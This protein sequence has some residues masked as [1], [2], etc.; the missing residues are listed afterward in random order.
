MISVIIVEDQEDTRFLLQTMLMN[1]SS[2][3]CIGTAVNGTESLSLIPSLQ[4]DVVLMDIG[5]PDISGVECVRRLK[6]SCPKVEFIMCTIMDTAESVFESI[7]AGASSYVLKN[8][9]AAEIITTIQEV[10]AG[11]SPMDGDI[12]RKMISVLQHK[13]QRSD[14]GITPKEHEV[15]ES[16]SKGFTYQEISDKL[17]ISVKTLKGHIYR[18]YQKLQVNNR[19][20]AINKYLGNHRQS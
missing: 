10:H 15:L 20:E 4:P 5:L 8:S 1:E 11:R 6:S 19:V 13:P 2:I 17:F 14:Y 16:L 9:A 12:A 18:I 7:L 3:N